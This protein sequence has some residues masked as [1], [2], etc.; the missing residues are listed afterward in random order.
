VLSGNAHLLPGTGQ[1]LD[2]ACGR[3]G[4]A[5]FLA[6]RGL[7]T[8]AWDISGEAIAALAEEARRRG[9]PV[10]AEER[11]VVAAP[12]PP[13]AFDVIVVSYFLERA[14][15][16]AITAALRPGGL[17]FYQTWIEEAVSGRGPRNP[18]YRLARNEL[19]R[20]FA[21]LD[22]LVYR[23]EGRTGEAGRGFRDEAMLVAMAPA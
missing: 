13:A 19:L 10:R 4:N 15:A 9:L 23:E 11:D 6:G 5:L 2:L 18:A 16:P 8:T 14:L 17:L 7:E 3:G 12:P 22:V 20:L 1:A 21:P